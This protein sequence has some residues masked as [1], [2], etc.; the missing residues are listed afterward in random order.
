M[1]EIRTSGSMSG[2]WNRSLGYRARL[3]LYSTSSSCHRGSLRR[4]R[5]AGARAGPAAAADPDL[6]LGRAR[7]ALRQSQCRPDATRGRAR[8]GV[9]APDA[10]RVPAVDAPGRA[11]GPRR[12]PPATAQGGV[13]P[14]PCQGHALRACA[15]G[16]LAQKSRGRSFDAQAPADGGRHRL[17]V[18]GVMAAVGRHLSPCCFLHFALPATGWHECVAQAFCAPRRG[19][20]RPVL[21]RL[22]SPAL[23][24]CW[25]LLGHR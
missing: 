3:R 6:G 9:I 23:G 17:S 22:G 25:P 19:S 16:Q 12:H 5:V 1:R 20:H 14:G 7:A 15:H 13:G 11:T 21:C 2:D 8:R 18:Q 10:D 4:C 24:R